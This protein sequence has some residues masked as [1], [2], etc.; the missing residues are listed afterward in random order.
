[1]PVA[2][3]VAAE[4]GAE[5]LRIRN[6]EANPVA[7]GVAAMAGVAVGV[8]VAAQLGVAAVPVAVPVAVGGVLGIAAAV[9]VRG[10]MGAGGWLLQ[11]AFGPKPERSLP[12]V[13]R[14]EV[15]AEAAPAS[16][17]GLEGEQRRMQEMVEGR[18]APA[19]LEV[20]PEAR[21]VLG[22]RAGL[23]PAQ[24]GPLDRALQRAAEE[25]AQEEAAREAAAMGFGQ[26]LRE[27]ARGY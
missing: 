9:G 14:P 2:V 17:G 20:I 5:V 23:D 19:E 26:R 27:G 10:A 24:P 12:F 25:A 13:H 11:R 16:V 15:V 21:E 6:P 4:S 18:V 8:G 1:M 22:Q 7:D 3:P